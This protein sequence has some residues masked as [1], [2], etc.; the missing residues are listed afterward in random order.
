M[1]LPVL[2]LMLS[3]LMLVLSYFLVRRSQQQ[4]AA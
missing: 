3:V 4:A 1:I 2:M